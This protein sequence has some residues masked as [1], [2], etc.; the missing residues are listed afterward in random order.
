[1]KRAQWEVDETNE[2]LPLPVPSPPPG[3]GGFSLLEMSVVLVIVGLLSVALWRFLPLFGEVADTRPPAEQLAL[4]NEAILGFTIKQYRLPCPAPVGGDGRE[5]HAGGTGQCQDTVGEFPFAT[6]GLRFPLRLRYG[7]FQNGTSLSL[8]SA[9]E[10][11]S[12]PLPPYPSP[13]NEWPLTVTGSYVMAP[14]DLGGLNVE[15]VSGIP[16]LPATLA[17]MSTLDKAQLTRSSSPFIG[18]KPVNGLDFCAALRDLQALPSLAGAPAV[19]GDPMAYAL[20]HPGTRDADDDGSFLDGINNTAGAFAVPGAPA[21]D[22]YDDHVLAVGFAELAGRLS[23]PFHLA[24][25]N[26][27]GRGAQA[28][29]DHFQFALAILQWRA[30]NLDLAHDDLQQ[31]YVSVYFSM[32]SAL[33]NLDQIAEKIG[34]FTLEASFMGVVN[35]LDLTVTLAKGTMGGYKLYDA[36]TGVNGKIDSVKSAMEKRVSA[37]AYADQ[38]RTLVETM[39]SRAVTLD[40]KGW[41][42]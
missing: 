7:A 10:R 3:A 17:E 15:G 20:A 35:A 5:R 40:E 14:G 25:A 30:F 26:M 41:L 29:Y 32:L 34:F 19:A 2:A 36:I 6:L 12:V 11:Y 42:P 24:R 31:A 27:A 4:A 8:T 13:T 38:I 28:A 22:L 9:Q 33:N 16:S 1:M 39:T 18:S 21:T 23:C 37:E